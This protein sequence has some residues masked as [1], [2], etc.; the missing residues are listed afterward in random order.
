MRKLKNRRYFVFISHNKKDKD[1][2]REISLFLTSENINV[3]FDEWEIS[4]GD[5][6]IDQID[7]GLENC[8]HFII[9]LSRNAK[10][11][12]WVKK[13]LKSILI[14]AIQSGNPVILPV[15][16]DKTPLP[17]LISDIH[18]I[19]YKG[20]TE[21]DR[22]EIIKAVTGRNPSSNFIKAIVKKYNEL[23]YDPNAKYPFPFLVC[24]SCGSDQL[25][26]S[27]M[28]DSKHDEIYFTVTCKECGWSEWTQ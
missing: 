14:D 2:A 24:P 22:W 26:H 7:K 27:S 9:I 15:I 21:E 1:A 4:A 28:T 16:L 10:R 25:K 23:I 5:S 13:E 12:N 6:I 18:Y 11:S 20:G 3:W 8:T 17:K 19:R